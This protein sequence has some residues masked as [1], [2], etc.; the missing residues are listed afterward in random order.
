VAQQAVRNTR[1]VVV[2]WRGRLLRTYYSSTCGGRTA[3]AADTWPTGPGYEFNLDLPIQA[4]PRDIA[5]ESSP[6]F[7]WE[8]VRDRAE[9]SKRIREWGKANAHAVV[10]VGLV[11][12]VRIVGTNKDERPNRYEIEDDRGRRF[13][14]GAEELRRACGQNVS[15]LAEVPREQRVWAG[16]MAFEVKGTKVTIRGR[17]FGHGVGMC[18]FCT[19]GFADRKEPWRETV[20]RYYPGAALERAY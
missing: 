19:K 13:A 1:G 10:G 6:R 7:K 11:S 3:S 18:Q 14:I 20:L 15:G 17:G 2:T 8:A 16:D 12:V 5:C 9:L 4:A